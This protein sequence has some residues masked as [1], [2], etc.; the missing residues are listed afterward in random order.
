MTTPNPGLDE[1]DSTTSIAAPK[2]KMSFG[3]W[4]LIAW[5]VGCGV[6]VL[7]I[8]IVV[9][10]AAV[11]AS[12]NEI[13]QGSSG[14]DSGSGSA[15]VA[16]QST[17]TPSLAGVSRPVRP[18]DPSDW[19]G[20]A[21]YVADVEFYAP[22]TGD[23]ELISATFQ[24]GTPIY[25]DEMTAINSSNLGKYAK[26]STQGFVL[27]SIS[28]SA[29]N[30]EYEICFQDGECYRK[31]FNAEKSPAGEWVVVDLWITS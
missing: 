1:P 7:V 26:H 4:F 8:I 13:N 16:P 11:G 17:P 23:L 24:P 10:I 22:A 21:Q 9:I 28:D 14:S 5:G 29:F 20:F 25:A 19:K 12:H 18:N 27:G 6:I 31:M 15:Q 30:A 3:K 2:K